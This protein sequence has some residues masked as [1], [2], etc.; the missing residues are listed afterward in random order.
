MSHLEANSQTKPS[1]QSYLRRL[2]SNYWFRTVLII[3]SG[4]FIAHKTEDTDAWLNTR[5]QVFR[6][7][8][9]LSPRSA[10][11]QRTVMIMI[12][13]EEYYRS[14]GELQRRVPLRRD[15]L[16]KLVDAAAAANAGVI[17]LDFTFSSPNPKGNPVELPPYQSETAQLIEAIR[18]AASAG[19]KVILTRTIHQV[20]QEEGKETYETESD[21]YG[22]E[23]NQW[24]NVSTGYHV[25]PDDVRTLPLA[26][27]SADGGLLESFCLAIA[28]ADNA[29][30]IKKLNDLTAVRYASFIPADEFSRLSADELL[31]GSPKNSILANRV[32]IISGAWHQFGFGRGPIVS[33]WNTPVGSLPGA[34]IH[35]NYF[36]SLF[37]KRFYRVWEDWP[38][39]IAETILALIVALAFGVKFRSR[40][41]RALVIA[42]PYI[43]ILLITYISLLS[44]A[45]FF[46]PFIPVLS[47]SAHGV[48]EQIMHWRMV[49]VKAI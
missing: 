37:D 2:L 21:I 22:S 7:L 6:W 45:W 18:R 38:K 15:Y 47:V 14:D 33:A 34:Y 17:A 43:A 26:V 1:K 41:K 49:A 20:S 40:T 5:Y 36:E 19:K 3:A 16:A 31:S 12:G 9:F 35:A 10:D 42:A 4:I 48:A 39:Y 24:E 32:A 29:A 28:R 25:L 44:F 27:R 13:D 30:S 46:D 8:Q 23:V 11:V